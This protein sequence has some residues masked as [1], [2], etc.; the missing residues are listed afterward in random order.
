L[1]G[2]KLNRKV[3]RSPFGRA[4][5]FVG[6]IGKKI[7]G[8]VKGVKKA[9]LDKVV[10]AP[11]ALK[12]N[13]SN[14]IP[15]SAKKKVAQ[16]LVKTATKKGLQKAGAKVGAKLAAKTAVKI[17]LKK[18]PV[19]GLIAGLGFGAQRLLAGDVQG[20]LMEAGSGIASTIPG[21]GTAISAGKDA[22]L[23]A[24]D[25]TGMKDGGEV[26]SPTQALIAEGGEPELVVPH[27]KLGPVFRSLLSN[28]GNILT[29]VTT[30]FLST[31]L[32]R[33]RKTG[34][35][36][37]CGTT[38][39]G[40]PPSA[41]SACVGELTSPPSF[42]PVT[43]LAIRAASF[44]ADIAVPGPGIV[45][46]IPDPASIRAPWTSPASN[47]CAPNPSPAMRPITGIFF[48][49]ILTAVLA[50]S[51]APTLAPAFCSPFFVAVFT[52]F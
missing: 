33:L 39:S 42:I 47:L 49:P 12:K 18:I 32:N 16:K 15:K 21:P 7:G 24:K 1:S 35:N 17:G 5:K 52:N 22:A 14:L 25:V 37:E 20:A 34:P 31:L 19:I 30:G 45:D 40:S 51:F 3:Q 10:T 44:P 2:L 28:V 29:D 46:A 13:I 11:A 26:S 4:K 6:G 41:I 23:I 38:S 9:A 36:L 50:A 27:S 48:N 8:K 43:S